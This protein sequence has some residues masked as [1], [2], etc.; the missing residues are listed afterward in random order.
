VTRYD[1][2]AGHPLAG[3]PQ[4]VLDTAYAAVGA[5]EVVNDAPDEEV[6][7]L[8]D[9]L[10]ANLNA[11][12]FITWPD[13]LPDRDALVLALTLEVARFVDDPADQR[14]TMEVAVDEVV[15]P[16]LR[17]LVGEPGTSPDR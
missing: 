16:L 11:R 7:F 1:E 10:V 12:G 15:M 4:E 17:R 9:A 2:V 5:W 8:A 6:R 14:G 3:V 13:R